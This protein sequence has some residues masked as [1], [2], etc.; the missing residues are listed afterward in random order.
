[1]MQNFSVTAKLVTPIISSPRANLTL[2][3]LLAARIYANTQSV[4]RAHADIPLD[5]DHGIWC[6]SAAFLSGMTQ[7]ASAIFKRGV[8]PRVLADPPYTVM[9]NG[10]NANKVANRQT[11]DQQRGPHTA[12]MDEYDSYA[13]ESVLWF[14]RGDLDQVRDLLR[15]VRFIGKKHHQGYGQISSR[16]GFVVEPLDDDEAYSIAIPFGGRVYPMR[17][18]P[19]T[20]WQ[21]MGHPLDA[22]TFTAD[23]SYQAPYFD[24]SSVARCATPHTKAQFWL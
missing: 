14:G 7:P 21:A 5:R 4:D 17:P 8:E 24:G 1:M 13:A 6:G 18:V 12:L 9:G 2:D 3:S 15:D 20:V 22:D 19:I 16:Q 10:R 11:V 23:V